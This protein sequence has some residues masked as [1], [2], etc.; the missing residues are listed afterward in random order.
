VM[1]NTHWSV[2][3]DLLVL[4]ASDKNTAPTQLVKVASDDDIII[5]KNKNSMLLS[6]FINNKVQAEFIMQSWQE[7]L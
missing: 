3:D 6:V 1:I 4:K 7:L 2:T 5:V